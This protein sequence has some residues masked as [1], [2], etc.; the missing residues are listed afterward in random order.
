[1]H[2]WTLYI[3]EFSGIHTNVVSR[4][5]TSGSKGQRSSLQGHVTYS[6]KMCNES[7]L[8]DRINVIRGSWHEHDPQLVENKSVATGPR[9]LHFMAAY[10]KNAKVYRLQIWVHVFSR[11]SWSR[12]PALGWIGQTKVEVTRVH[13]RVAQKTDTFLK[14]STSYAFTVSNI[15]RFSNVAVGIRRKFAIILTLKIPSH[16]KCVTTLPWDMT[17]LKSNNWKRDFCNDIF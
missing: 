9:N 1:M 11:K 2:H 16:L 10:F 4:D 5:V 3:I 7:V 15:D 13:Y 12:D 14:A 6:I 17:C 8:A